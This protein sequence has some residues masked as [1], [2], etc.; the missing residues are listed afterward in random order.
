MSHEIEQAADNP[1]GKDHVAVFLDRNQFIHGIYVHNLR[2]AQ[3]KKLA[4]G[5]FQVVSGQIQR[6]IV[7][8]R[9]KLDVVVVLFLHLI[10]QVLGDFTAIADAVVV[11]V[12]FNETAGGEVNHHRLDIQW[13]FV[14]PAYDVLDGEVFV[15]CTIEKL[16]KCIERIHGVV[17][18]D[19]MHHL[20]LI[21]VLRFKVSLLVTSVAHNRLELN[22]FFRCHPLHRFHIHIQ[23]VIR[24]EE[25]S[26]PYT[27]F[28]PG[29]QQRFL[30]VVVFKVG[31]GMVDGVGFDIK[32][33][34]CVF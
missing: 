3:Y 9:F 34:L 28:G 8:F 23:F 11:D 10:V 29:N 19:G 4:T 30:L 24:V 1:S 26:A 2:V 7:R 25:R 31:G 20:L 27:L 13:W 15:A 6:S 22:A 33:D 21:V 12:V 18:G 17:A 14:E 16:P 5:D 32:G